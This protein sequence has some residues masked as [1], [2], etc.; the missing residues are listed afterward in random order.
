[1]FIFGRSR[2]VVTY[3]ACFVAPFH[4]GHLLDTYLMIVKYIYITTSP[5]L[6]FQS[7]DDQFWSRFSLS[8][9]KIN[10]AQLTRVYYSLWPSRCRVVNFVSFIKTFPDKTCRF[11][12]RRPTRVF[13]IK[14]L[15]VLIASM[16]YISF[17]AILDSEYALNT[18][19]TLSALCTQKR[20]FPNRKVN[21]LL[22]TPTALCRI[23]R[24]VCVCVA[25]WFLFVSKP[26]SRTSDRQRSNFN[27]FR[28]ERFTLLFSSRRSF[29]GP[30][31]RP[32]I[33]I[34]HTFLEW[35][36]E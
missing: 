6:V 4:T 23:A 1:M 22:E 18:K 2:W 20:T 17:S 5:C 3:S 36:C 7:I 28:R 8:I 24:N 32:K 34:K 13:R 12:F 26:W 11:Q 27:S 16:T 30:P 29:Q 14:L 19:Q 31:Y 35:D 33:R 10:D 25:T 21:F 15:T 9:F